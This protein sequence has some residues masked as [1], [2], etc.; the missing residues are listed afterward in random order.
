[1]IFSESDNASIWLGVG[2]HARIY[3]ANEFWRANFQWFLSARYFGLFAEVSMNDIHI[4]LM[5]RSETRLEE[6]YRIPCG[7]AKQTLC[8]R[9]FV[10][11][12][13]RRLFKRILNEEA[14]TY[15]SRS[16]TDYYYDCSSILSKWSRFLYK[17]SLDRD[18]PPSVGHTTKRNNTLIQAEWIVYWKSD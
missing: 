4:W 2:C 18:L 11:K 8:D 10:R 1:M 5:T 17:L 6:K 16:T 9:N 12:I 7:R 15:F 3:L 13:D 14:S